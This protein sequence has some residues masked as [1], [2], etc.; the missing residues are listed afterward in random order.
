MVK[1]I[2]LTLDKDKDG[3]LVDSKLLDFQKLHELTA[4]VINDGITIS[5]EFENFEEVPDI[6]LYYTEIFD[7]INS[8][9]VDPEIIDLNQK[10][11]SASK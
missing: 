6:K 2:R 8:L 3:V 1:L 4:E 9:A 10:I 5:V 11:A 7:S